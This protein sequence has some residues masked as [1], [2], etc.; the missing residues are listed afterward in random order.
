MTDLIPVAQP[1]ERLIVVHVDVD[2]E[3]TRRLQVVGSQPPVFRRIDIDKCPALLVDGFLTELMWLP[4]AGGALV[5]ISSKSR[6]VR[7]GDLRPGT[8][9]EVLS[10]AKQ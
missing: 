7:F 4:E 8:E 9:I 3:D 2:G 1:G 10:Y 5:S 6:A